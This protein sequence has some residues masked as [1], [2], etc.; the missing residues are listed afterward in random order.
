MTA[1]TKLYFLIFGIANGLFLSAALL[2]IG[3]RQSKATAKYLAY[4][5]MI[6]TCLLLVELLDVTF[7]WIIVPVPLVLLVGPCLYFYVRSVILQQHELNATD[8]VHFAPSIL[9]FVFFLTLYLLS[10]DTWTFDS[11][12]A[13]ETPSAYI[14]RLSLIGYSVYSIWLLSE[15]RKQV[16]SANKRDVN[17]LYGWFVLLVSA[18]ICLILFSIPPVKEKFGIVEQDS[19]ATVVIVFLIHSLGFISLVRRALQEGFLSHRKSKYKEQDVNNN[20]EVIFQYLS[21]K[22]PFLEPTFSLDDLSEEVCLSRNIISDCINIGFEKTFNELLSDYRT[23]EFKSLCSKAENRNKSVLELAY[24]SG[25]NS[26]AAF[27][28]AFRAREQISPTEF[29]K[30]FS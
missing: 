10:L 30:Q 16:R 9:S 21:H 20:V 8:R 17:T 4:I 11:V 14:Q 26:K 7:N 28:R 2:T 6:F 1:D 24:A 18:T 23:S 13:Y 19:I 22:K 15:N 12:K 3:S 29:R 27:Y 5:L 25:F